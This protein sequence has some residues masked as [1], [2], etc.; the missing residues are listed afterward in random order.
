MSLLLLSSSAFA[1]NLSVTYYGAKPA[2]CSVS[3][4]YYDGD[5]NQVTCAAE[6]IGIYRSAGST[7]TLSCQGAGEVGHLN[8]DDSAVLILSNCTESIKAVKATETNGH[9]ISKGADK[10]WA[11]KSDKSGI[12]NKVAA[13]TPIN[14]CYQRV[15]I[16]GSKVR[17]LLDNSLTLDHAC[18]ST[19]LL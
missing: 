14:N 16:A 3:M 10:F 2:Q 18:K 12:K 7:V 6:D 1:G 11:R 15:S 8:D 9:G 13:K 4:E 19:T 5:K 17:V